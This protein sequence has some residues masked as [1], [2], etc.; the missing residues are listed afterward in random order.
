MRRKEER[1][2]VVAPTFVDALRERAQSVGGNGDEFTFLVDGEDQKDVLSIVGLDERARAVAAELTMVGASGRQVLI[3]CP[4]GLDY[5]AA[6]FGCLYAGS[7]AIPVFP[8]DPSRLDAT[9]PR[10]QAVAADSGAGF[11]VTSS[12]TLAMVPALNRLAPD[13]AALRWIAADAV[14]ADAGSWHERR[15][16]P[17]DLA[18]LFYTSGSTGTP[19]GVMVSHGNLVSNV[20]SIVEVAGLDAPDAVAVSWLPMYHCLGLLA[21][22]L[23]IVASTT[24]RGIFMSPLAFL[25]SPLRWLRAISRHRA[26]ASPSMNFGYEA[27]VRRLAAGKPADMDEWQLGQWRSA[28]NGG[29][30]VRMETLEAFARAFEP[31]GF[32][33]SAFA[34]GY[35]I[36]EATCLVSGHS[37]GEHGPQSLKAIDPST[38]W[39]V[40]RGS[41]GRPTRDQNVRIVDPQTLRPRE[42]GEI[43]EIWIS[44]PS[45]TLGYWKRE[46]E[47]RATFGAKIDGDPITPYLRTGDL[48]IL[49][50]GEIYIIGRLKE[51]II[52]RGRNHYPEDIERTTERAHTGILA[53]C[54]AAFSVE[55]KGTEELAVVFESN[56]RDDDLAAAFLAVRAAVAKEHSL[57]PHILVAVA[58]G[59]LPRTQTGK[60]RR[61]PTRQ[62]LLAGSLTTVGEWR[63]EE[64]PAPRAAAPTEAPA[65]LAPEDPPPQR[66]DRGAEASIREWLT[67]A[68]ATKTGSAIDSVDPDAP[69]AQ[70]GLDS[71]ATVELSGELSD[72]LKRPLAPSLVYAHP[73]IAQLARWL[74]SS[75]AS[76]SDASSSEPSAAT[77]KDSSADAM[78][79]PGAV[80]RAASSPETAE[81]IAIIGVS[82]RVPGANTPEEF[83]RL[84]RAGVDCVAEIP[85]ER[86]DVNAYSAAEPTSGKS[87]TN[88][89]AMLAQVDRF[90][91]AFFGISPREAKGMDP[92]HRFLLESAWEAFENARLAPSSLAGTATG[93]FVGIAGNDYAQLQCRSPD[94]TR[95]DAY[96]GTGV[97]HSTAAGR[98][99]YLLGLEG[100]SVALDTACSSSLVAVHLA[101][102]SLQARDCNLALA[103]GVNLILAPEGFIYLSTVGALS[104]DGRSKA[105]DEHTNGYGR[106]EGCAFVVLK[107][108]DDALAA[109][110]PILAVIRGTAVNQDGRSNGLTAPNPSAQKT[111][112][113]KALSRAGVRAADVDYVEAHGTGTPLG[114]PIE[115]MALGEVMRQER[116]ASSPLLIGSL[117]R[118][119]GHL[120]SAAGVVGLIKAV[121]ALH[122][123]EIP[124]QLVGAPSTRIDWRRLQLAL[125]TELTPWPRRERRPRFAGVSSFGMS[126]TNAHVVVEEAPRLPERAYVARGL[127]A[128]P[129]SAHSEAALREL[130]QRFEETLSTADTAALRDACAGVARGR[131]AFAHRVTF[132]ASTPEGMVDELALFRDGVE[133]PRRIA[134]RAD[135]AKP[136]VAFLYTGQGA[137]YAGV[138]RDL[139]E[140]EP[141]FR[142]ALERCDRILMPRIGRSLIELVYAAAEKN[143]DR[144]EA[145]FTQPALFALQYALTEQWRSWGV[146]PDIVLGHSLGEFAAACAAGL[147]GLEDGLALVAAR[148]R[149]MQTLCPKGAMLAVDI[150]EARLPELRA[151]LAASGGVVV[152][153]A[154]NAPGR[155]TLAGEVDVIARLA[156]TLA[157][158][159][160]RTKL[161][162]TTRAFHSP[163]MDAAREPFA[164]AIAAVRFD[165]PTTQFVSSVTG[166]LA[167]HAELASPSYWVRQ[168]SMPVEFRRALST[169]N[170]AGVQAPQVLV[171]IGA[172][173]VLLGIHRR[174][175]SGGRP[176]V[177]APSLARDERDSER[178]IRS[179]A[180]LWARGVDV[181][182]A[183][184]ETGENRRATFLPT[185]PFQ[186]SRYWLDSALAEST[187]TTAP[188]LAAPPKP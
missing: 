183:A 31:C 161:L 27:C 182:W 20:S 46:E 168:M 56:L 58:E 79:T 61:C 25:Q 122:H 179:L 23:P 140:T 110:D 142:A 64:R 120:E 70:Y 115:A 37:V 129:L 22:V 16:N 156:E 103:G 175:V 50:N 96:T 98:L 53:G 57:S 131:S 30:P 35:G 29:E 148:G 19:K 167:T 184:V 39:E 92:Q 51:L 163:L 177:R 143:P 33:R 69:F 88:N 173:P 17:E 116:D 128:L 15:P 162:E 145:Q 59:A 3:M 132:L 178:M 130:A 102:Q 84:L 60:I 137:D 28:P 9:L 118:Q 91:A 10:L 121:L 63:A 5:I 77:P 65:G 169:L 159:G 82:C 62:A 166:E 113:R 127:H 172:H 114:D 123:E 1:S 125:P 83:W 21:S 76:S 171:E 11:V 85:S 68:V 141:V 181:R 157:E 49:K 43:G 170:A 149:L 186:R 87:I 124:A 81:P 86:W 38:G 126:G 160:A 75:D 187:P 41:C 80:H 48:G 36:S 185:Y 100:P 134:G 107:R 44:G 45:V 153:A 165:V 106:G 158:A 119:I 78:A 144:D 40:E 104:P 26:T 111:V 90:D 42:E 97:F 93:V 66:N 174:C 6:F 146:V 154:E 73:T 108:R 136:Q 152:V 52:V 12:Q 7:I 105:F 164:K 138:G 155:I 72:W 47:T 54:T 150:D 18:C 101:C 14:E 112:I 99:S 13:L 109:G 2:I 117:K 71:K 180:A 67:R 4:S 74:A 95:I 32:R 176:V 135:S 147:F 89:A 55:L 24:A 133:S 94:M 151:S 34:P 139:F 188:L 8:P